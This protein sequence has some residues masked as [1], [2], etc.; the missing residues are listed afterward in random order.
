[1]FANS[2]ELLKYIKDNGVAQTTI[3]GEWT[4][5]IARWTAI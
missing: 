2:D 5:C 1:M 3:D 4:A